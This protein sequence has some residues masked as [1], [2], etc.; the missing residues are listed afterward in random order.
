MNDKDHHPGHRSSLRQFG[1]E[2][3]RDA[4][5]HRQQMMPIYMTLRS[6]STID[7]QTAVHLSNPSLDSVM[8]ERKRSAPDQHD[9]VSSEAVVVVPNAHRFTNDRLDAQTSSTRRATL[10]YRSRKSTST[11]RPQ[12]AVPTPSRTRTASDC[13][14]SHAHRALAKSASILTLHCHSSNAVLQL[15]RQPSLLSRLSHQSA[16]RLARHSLMAT[17]G[18]RM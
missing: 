7:E 13:R 2:R 5:A 14:R 10:K 6:S 15:L 8:I 4:N 17:I 3:D 11:P 9:Q 12:T 18:C 16:S 1:P